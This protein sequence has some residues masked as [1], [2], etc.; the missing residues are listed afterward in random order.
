MFSFRSIV[1]VLGGIFAFGIF[2][3]FF[4]IAG[5]TAS[6][7]KITWDDL[8]PTDT[9]AVAV[10]YS[11]VQ[12]TVDLATLDDFD[13]DQ[14][15]LDDYLE[16]MDE[17]K[18]TQAGG[19]DTIAKNLDQQNVKIA[20]YITPIE[21]DGERVTEFFLVPYLGACAHVPPPPANQIIYVE[22]VEGLSADNLYD[23]IYLVGK[24]DAKPIATMVANIGYTVKNA[25]VLPFDEIELEPRRLI[26]ITEQSHSGLPVE[27]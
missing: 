17:V 24:L 3:Q 15:S 2:F 10:D 11:Q 7:K 22:N 18:A 4:I 1:G 12:N 25:Q 27:Q 9:E 14:Q 19:G 26:E 23:P 16:Y 5:V 13:G 6:P 20:G 8:V 21:F